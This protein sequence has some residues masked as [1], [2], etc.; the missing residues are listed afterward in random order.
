MKNFSYLLAKKKSTNSLRRKGSESNLQTPSD[1]LP[2]EA[3][4]ARYQSA[5]YEVKLEEE[6]SYM[7]ESN[8]G[9]TDNSESVYLDLFK[10]KQAVPQDSLFRDDLFKNVCEKIQNRNEAM[11]IQDITR[12][13]VPSAQNLAIYGAT[14]LG[15][16]YET[17]NEGW[18]NMNG[19]T[20]CARPQPDYSV[21]F[22][23]SA[24]TDIQRKKLEPFVGSIES[25]LT[26]Y[27]MATSN[28]YFPF[29]TCEVKCGAAALSVADRQNAH[30]MTLAVRGVVE[31][32][33]LV[34][35]QKELHRE[36]LAYSVSHDHRSVRIYGH[37]A[38]IDGDNTTFYRHPIHEFSFTAM[39]GKEKWTTYKFTK[40]LYDTWMPEHFKRICSAID[41]IPPDINF[42]VSELPD[43]PQLG[44]DPQRSLDLEGQSSQSSLTDSQSGFAGSQDAT[45]TT[46][47]TEK[48]A[49]VFKKPKKTR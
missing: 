47:F 7:R 45:P 29:L 35:R 10:S 43:S 15:H 25:N 37:Y 41:A 23:R 6:G 19:F 49:P 21:G 40:N 14:H 12:L 39:N 18:N 2:R 46:S 5:R 17:V 34:E 33:K 13:I 11:V 31:L 22:G 16:L 30:S 26:S 1:Q 32:Y 27:F 4:S 44:Q 48:D 28:M 42:E 38:S 20:W 24:F 9:I 8:L 36:I 3:K